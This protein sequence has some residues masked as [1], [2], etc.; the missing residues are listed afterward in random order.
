MLQITPLQA[1][2]LEDAAA[3]VSSR[4]RQLRQAR[5]EL[6][7]RYTRVDTLL[8][9]LQ[10]I[11]DAS[12]TGVVASRGERL[13]GFLTAWQMRSFRGER[14]TYSPEWA[15]GVDLDDSGRIYIDHRLFRQQ[16]PATRG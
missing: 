1:D 12:G 11:W 6:P 15:N 5:P 3:L 16:P 7:A 14:S 13:V 10:A 9:L 4:Y 2:H 8:P